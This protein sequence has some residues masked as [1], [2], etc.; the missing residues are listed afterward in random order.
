MRVSYLHTEIPE[1]TSDYLSEGDVVVRNLR[2]VSLTEVMDVALLTMRIALRIGIQRPQSRHEQLLPYDDDNDNLVFDC[3]LNSA[4]TG[5]R[6][7]FLRG[8]KQFQSCIKGFNSLGLMAEQ[9]LRELT[10]AEK[11]GLKE[12]NALKR[13]FLKSRKHNYTDTPDQLVF[14]AEEVD[15]LTDQDLTAL[16]LFDVMIWK[17]F[18]RKTIVCSTSSNMGISLHE[19]LRYMQQSSVNAFGKKFYLLNISEGNLII[20][21]PDREADFMNK[22]KSN[23][24]ESLEVELPPLTKL[25]TYINR[26]QRDPGALSDAFACGGYFFPTNP[27]SKDEIQNLLFFSLTQIAA[28]RKVTISALTQDPH[29]KE[30]LNSLRCEIQEGK[31]Y[32][33][34]GIEGGISG[35]MVPYLIM[36]EEVLSMPKVKA[37]STWN[38]ASIGAALAAAVIA[39]QILRNPEEMN[40]KTRA[41]LTTLFPNISKFIDLKELGKDVQTRIHGLFD[42]ANIQ[43]LAQLL[44]VVV[45][46]HLSGRGTAFVG[47]GSSSYSNGNRCYEILKDS[48]EGDGSFRGK[49]TFHPATHTLNP[50]AQALIYGEDLY[51]IIQH[52]KFKALKTEAERLKFIQD[53]VKKSEPAGA[54]AMAG[55]LL[56]RLD[57]GN[58]SIM[59]IAYLLK[60]MGFT[61]QLFLEFSKFNPDEKGLNLFMQESYEEGVYMGDLAKNILII[62]DWP[63]QEIKRRAELE[64]IHSTLKYKLKPI[65]DFWVDNLDP[66]VNI[67]LTGD[68]TAQPSDTLNLT[69]VQQM[70]TN[71]KWIQEYLEGNQRMQDEQRKFNSI[72]WVSSS[73]SA[74]SL[75]L[76]SW[77]K[78]VN[79]LM[80]RTLNN[81]VQKK[82]S[83]ISSHPNHK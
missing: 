41:N 15:A 21:C 20:W 45:E 32:V 8:W 3:P 25:R 58:L 68:N 83:E 1:I 81:I 19:D 39:D 7:T 31:I 22:E 13:E 47:L 34:F 65:D 46:R 76:N 54:A 17:A 38:Q 6:I 79:R 72:N 64:K 43:S 11:L 10:A 4:L 59:E 55:Y 50:F 51:K 40:E 44:G 42:L 24:L 27:Q 73:L 28:E 18:A 57:F 74:L 80:T 49:S 53:H 60:L 75:K 37:L 77:D 2:S 71:E 26:I 30:T 62:L 56:T 61:K 69:L 14:T 36:L 33:D 82:V 9:V 70:Q 23:L 12:V 78:K 52:A 29:I 63:L 67:Y 5:R 35:L 66:L 48:M 16:D